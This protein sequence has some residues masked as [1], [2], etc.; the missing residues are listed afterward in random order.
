MVNIRNMTIKS[1]LVSIIIVVCLSAL[2]LTGTVLFRFMH[3]SFRD[4][5][6]NEMLADAEIMAENCNVALAFKNVEDVERT[7]ASFK[8]KPS[9]VYI[10]VY[11]K[12]G[13]LFAAYY[14]EDVD[15]SVRPLQLAEEGCL[16][17]DD[18][19]TVFKDIKLDNEIVGLLCLRSDLS[20]LYA[21]VND[22]I[23]A[24]VATIL[25]SILMSWFLASKLQKVISVPILNLA[26]T[27]NAISAQKDYTVRAQ[28]THNDEVGQLIDSFND[29]L[30]QIYKRDTELKKAKQESEAANVAKSH[31]LANMSHEIRTPMNA[32][33]G[34]A[35][36]LLDEG[37]TV[38]Q[39]DYLNI[40]CTSSKHLLQIIND[41]LD[42]SKIEA[43]KLDVE[44]RSCSLGETLTIIENMISG[45]TTD[46]NL[47]FEIRE[48]SGLPANIHTDQARLQQCLINL[49]NNAVKFTE[50]GHIYL[51]VFLEDR[52]NQPFIRFDVEDTG[53]GIPEERQAAIFESFTQADG[54]TS[55]KYGGTGLGLT[56]T[57]QLTE[58]L[59]GELT[60]V[61]EVG[62][63][64]VFS[65]VI[66]AGVDVT[67]QP[68]LDRYNVASSADTCY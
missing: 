37:L 4:S 39:T 33:V 56:I 55:R 22:A 24:I 17:E 42:F 9:V 45:I 63:G 31:F 50:R 20:Y 49:I 29:M 44:K 68:F 30:E 58:L 38:D 19:L 34:F 10:G 28:K 40:I 5:M 54:S 23:T 64:S 26:N 62:K 53:I 67:K 35:T 43:G 60:L 25:L 36:L 13:E 41:I 3:H 6:V 27:A 51:S 57:K 61:S 12:G 21:T 52:D 18:F 15:H 59:G 7:L 11:V 48:D 66:P 32:V 65:M 14:R 2:T 8:L 47:T 1:K 46:K 16:F